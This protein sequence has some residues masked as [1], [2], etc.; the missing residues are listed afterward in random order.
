MLSWWRKR[1]G[2]NTA[3]RW[4][5][6]D[7]E[8]SGLDASTDELVSIGGVAMV[9][10]RVV[11]ADSIE[12]V[13]K[14]QTPSSRDNIVVH[15]IGAH[16]QLTG[17]DRGD[18][19]RSFMDFVGQAPLLAFHAPFDR[20]FLARAIKVYVNQPFDNRWLDLADLAPVLDSSARLNSLDEWLQ[21]YRIPVIVRHSAAADAFATAL[22]AARLLPAAK[23]QGASDFVSLQRLARYARWLH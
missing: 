3:R 13:V 14:R 20:G 11:P 4:V 18:A 15:G 22:L 2:P 23:L 21:R 5:V 7:I 9:G 17:T 12:I 1:S 10:G 16:A 8:T 19:L 6:V